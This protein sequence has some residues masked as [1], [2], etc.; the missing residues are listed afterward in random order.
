[1]ASTDLQDA[2][3]AKLLD[4]LLRRWRSCTP[5]ELAMA[6]R[7]PSYLQKPILNMSPDLTSSNV[8]FEMN[9]SGPWSKAEAYQHLGASRTAT[10]RAKSS[11]VSGLHAPRK[12]IEFIQYSHVD[13]KYLTGSV[14]I[15]DIGGPLS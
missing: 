6:V 8:L 14:R 15:T 7:P 4:R 9:S 2:W 12:P 1:M 3:F 11:A 10:V 13:E 5:P